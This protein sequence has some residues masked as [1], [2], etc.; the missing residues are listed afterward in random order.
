MADGF[1]DDDDEYEADDSRSGGNDSELVRD[2]RR[3]LKQALK[4]SKDTAAELSKFRAVER[5]R[6]LAS[7]LESRGL[8]PKIA[9]LIPS[10]VA[11]DDEALSQWLDDYGDVF[12]GSASEPSSDTPPAEQDAGA[13]ERQRMTAL[14]ETGSTPAGGFASFEERMS[15]ANSQD[16]IA[17]ILAEARQ[18]IT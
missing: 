4:A 6:S 12:G 5:E 10:E 16:E 14:A 9:K 17:Q 11:E 3:Q 7:K 15:R 18:Y 2:L 1:Y 13:V 8:K